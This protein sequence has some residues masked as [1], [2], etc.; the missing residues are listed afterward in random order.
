MAEKIEP[1]KTSEVVE[2]DAPIAEKTPEVT[3]LNTDTSPVQKEEVLSTENEEQS[4]SE[5][6]LELQNSDTVV[7]ET[8]E[9]TAE[10]V[11]VEKK[12]YENRQQVIDRLEEIVSLTTDEAKNEVNHL[13]KV[14]YMLR[15]QETDAALQKILESDDDVESMNY[16]STP[17][18]LEEHLKELLNKHKEVRAAVVEARQK[19]LND[20]A[21]KKIEILNQMESLCE[22]AEH[23]NAHYQTFQELQKQFKQVGMVDQAVVNDLW[24]RFSST[25]EKFY[26]LLKINKELRDYDFKKNLEKKEALCIEAESLGTLG[27]VI[28]AFRRLQDL[29]EEWKGIGPVAP[30]IRE[31]LWTRFKAASTII[32]KRHQTHFENIKAKEAE[33]EAG[34]TAICEKIEALELANLTTMKQ[35]EEQTS[36]VLKL[37]EEWR[38]FGYASKKVNNQLFERFRKSC[39]EFFAA[40]ARYFH[41]LK[42]AQSNNVQKKEKLCQ[43]A[44]ELMS[45]TDWRKTT[46]QFINLQR[47]WKQVG[48][49]PRKLSTALWTRFV[50]ACDAFF[51]AK[52]KAVGNEK[53]EEAENLKKKR[54]IIARL[55]ELKEKIDSVTPEDIRSIRAEWNAIG[56][57]PFKEKDKVFEDYQK[58]LDIFYEKL[59][60]KGM[61]ARMNAYAENVSKIASGD[62]S[63]GN[64]LRERER[65]VR[66]YERLKGE[67]KTYENNL[68]FLTLSSKGSNSLMREIEKKKESLKTE[69]KTLVEKI[70][71]ID[72][73]L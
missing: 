9:N 30:A 40:K 63:Q 1:I 41:D 72:K 47:E 50:T 56:H 12:T 46:D 35:W 61:K 7:V 49:V 73:N 13:K 34:K 54:E 57:V 27:D 55:V 70:E 66:V 31:D 20:N 16:Q 53:Q 48:P 52:E 25:M 39:D 14:Y 15:Q 17:D 60:M 23:V 62:K 4:V 19:E 11:V 22:D 58:A 38:S 3:P 59:D 32:N 2:T 68:G 6:D 10:E 24:K 44:E 29:H 51:A 28:A 42:D 5:N 67:L 8:E 18:D 33:N 37:Q 21:A 64:L 65:L 45:S 36:F 43:R 69:I 71:L 26:D